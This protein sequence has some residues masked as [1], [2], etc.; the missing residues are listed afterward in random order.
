MST[1]TSTRVGGSKWNVVDG[2]EFEN[3]MDLNRFSVFVEEIVKGGF[4]LIERV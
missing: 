1:S 3:G 4:E 2:K